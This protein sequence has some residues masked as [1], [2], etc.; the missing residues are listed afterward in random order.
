MLTLGTNAKDLYNLK[1][2][3]GRIEY[4]RAK[5]KDIREDEAF[6]SIK[7]E[8]ELLP[9]LERNKGKDRVFNFSEIH[10]KH[11]RLIKAIFRGMK[12][13]RK[14][15]G[16]DSLVYYD[17]RRTVASV[18]RNKLGISKDDVAMC[19]NHV[20]VD[21]RVTDICIETDFSV[22]DK[23]NR[24]FLD[25]LFKKSFLILLVQKKCTRRFANYTRVF[26]IF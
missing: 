10:G 26:S 22:L 25:W 24:A 19:L 4:K 9:Y 21:H 20:D 18:M 12:E 16:I 7:I 13:I 2:A 15:T 8:P 1:E 23:C 11:E 5:T 17:A 6:I 14:V 3:T